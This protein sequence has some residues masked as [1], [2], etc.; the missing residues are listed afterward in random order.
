MGRWKNN[1]HINNKRTDTYECR[2]DEIIIYREFMVNGLTI[3]NIDF[4]SCLT[5]AVSQY[6][7]CAY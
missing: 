4:F 3:N 7:Y 5:T 1:L 2:A 6:N